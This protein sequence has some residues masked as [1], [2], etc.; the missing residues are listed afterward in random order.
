VYDHDPADVALLG[1]EEFIARQ[2]ASIFSGYQSWTGLRRIGRRWAD[3]IEVG[4]GCSQ[5]LADRLVE[6]EIINGPDRNLGPADADA[7]LSGMFSVLA[8]IRDDLAELGDAGE[9]GPD[10]VARLLDQHSRLARAI[11]Q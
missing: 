1:W 4:L 7:V 2:W 9:L 5:E 3:L 8:A 10:L 6:E 11:G